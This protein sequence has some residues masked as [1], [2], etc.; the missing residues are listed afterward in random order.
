[1]AIGGK[2]KLKNNN[3]GRKLSW[4]VIIKEEKNLKS[5]DWGE[6]K[7]ELLLLG[8]HNRIY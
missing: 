5:N 1:M 8:R 4:E 2:K 7:V 3:E 6:K